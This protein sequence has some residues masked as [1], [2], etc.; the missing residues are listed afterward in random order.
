VI[1][2]GE[3]A[4]LYSNMRKSRDHVIDYEVQPKDW[5]HPADLV[6]ITEQKDEH[7]THRRQQE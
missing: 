4:K 3:A 7:A 1:R 6:T 5:L 2:A